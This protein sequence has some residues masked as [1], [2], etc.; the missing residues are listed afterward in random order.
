MA[1]VARSDEEQW[2]DTYHDKVRQAVIGNLEPDQIRALHTAIAAKL[3]T[4][5]KVHP[6]TKA[7]HWMAAGDHERAAQYM[8]EA[9]D[10][11]ANQLAL[12]RAAELY[13]QVL[14]LIPEDAKG[15]NYDRMRC[16]AA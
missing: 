7:R 12:A 3:E 14:E 4:W 13:H 9:A 5:P 16:R 11:A 15:P 10:Q 1:R 6:A 8:I 2:L